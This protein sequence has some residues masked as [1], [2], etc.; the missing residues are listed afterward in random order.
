MSDCR[1]MAGAPSCTMPSARRSLPP[2]VLAVLAGCATAPAGPPLRMTDMPA[3]PPPQ[4]GEFTALGEVLYV[5]PGGNRSAAYGAW[6]VVGPSV[7]ITYTGNDVWAG[8]LDGRNVSLTA[9]PGR[10]TGA[11]VDLYLIR[12][13]DEVTIRGLWF[14]RSV[15][16]VM[17]ATHLQGHTTARGPGFEM[18]RVSPTFMSGA[19]G[20]AG[21]AS[22]EMRGQAAQFP[23]VIAPH[24][25]LALLAALP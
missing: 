10:L 13:G 7:N 3:Q 20:G 24:F 23:D 12:E 6:R 1:S 14:Q 17:S 16:I 21:S 8:N 25:H 4:A 2:L 15:W 9:A 22:L 19:A 11:G 5:G 18:K